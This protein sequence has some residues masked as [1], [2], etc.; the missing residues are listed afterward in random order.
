MSKRKGKTKPSVKT[1]TNGKPDWKTLLAQGLVALIV[2]ALVEGL[3][4]LLQ[5]FFSG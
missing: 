1:E 2:G 4:L 5:N 3:K